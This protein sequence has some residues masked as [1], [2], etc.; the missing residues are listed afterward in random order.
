MLDIHCHILP[1][2]DDGPTSLSE[3]L[4]MLHRMQADGVTHV[5]ATPHCNQNLQLFRDVIPLHVARLNEAAQH[6]KIAVTVLSGS[7]IALQHTENYRR[8]YEQGKLCH[9]GDN[10][11]F[12]LLEFPWQK[13]RFPEGVVELLVWLRE[14]GTTPIVAHPER[15][16]C[17]RENREMLRRLV[18]AGAWLQITVD[19]LCGVNTPRASDIAREIISEYSNVVLASDSHNLKRCSGLSIGYETVEREWSRARADDLKNRADTILQKIL[20]PQ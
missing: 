5:I 19:S 3:S 16:P 18:D 2:V 11:K 6:K 17:L 14:R 8:N 1:Q 20:S 7:E 9:L 10:P 4:A 15:T 12:S 13:E